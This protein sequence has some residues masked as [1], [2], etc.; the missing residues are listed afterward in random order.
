ML[1]HLGLLISL[2]TIVFL[3]T[4]KVRAAD[5]SFSNTTKTTYEVDESGVT[6]V[7]ASISLTNLTP[8][9]YAQSYQLKTTF[10]HIYDIVATDRLGNCPTSIS[11]NTISVTFNDKVVG[12]G[13]IFRWLLT[14]KTDELVTKKGLIWEVSLP[15]T[16][17][18]NDSSSIIV[19]KIPLSF[20]KPVGLASTSYSSTTNTQQIYVINETALQKNGEI[21]SFGNQQVFN[22]TLKYHLKNLN[23]VPMFQEIALPPNI[24]GRQETEVVNLTPNPLGLRTDKDGNYLAKYFLWPQQE[25]EIVLAGAAKTY[26]REIGINQGAPPGHLDP[27][28]TSLLQPQP[29]WEVKDP[30]ITQIAAGLASSNKTSVENAKQIYDYVV[31]TLSYNPN[32][33]FDNRLGA[34]QVL[35]TP[36]DAVCGEFADLF[37]ALCRAAGIPARELEGYAATNDTDRPISSDVLHAWAEFYDGNLGW[38]A[39]DP[40]WGNTAKTD[41]FTHLD[42]TR[43]VL[44]THGESSNSPAPAGAYKLDINE[45]DQVAVVIGGKY[46]D[47]AENSESLLRNYN[48]FDFLGHLL[49]AL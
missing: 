36:T 14:Y 28:L 11:G 23:L 16:E 39:V 12:L 40:T 24:S 1:K 33:G 48:V 3:S 13:A 21:I 29:F 37:V 35:K 15:K 45:K 41:F 27:Y 9:F 25:I 18:I 32:K 38:V 4:T 30:Q 10:G 8:K 49:A 2:L 46:P 26:N 17:G 31:S 42:S 5:Q 7:T 43:L 6:T 22:Y 19:L 34:S 47:T 44:A 20:G